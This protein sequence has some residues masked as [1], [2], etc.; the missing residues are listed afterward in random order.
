MLAIRWEFHCFDP[1]HKRAGGERA[2]MKFANLQ[3]RS[4]AGVEPTER[5]VATPHRF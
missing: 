5:G 3:E 1:F 4:G 2:L